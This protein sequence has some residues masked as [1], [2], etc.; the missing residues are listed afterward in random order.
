MKTLKGAQ[1]LLSGVFVIA[2]FT[3]NAQAPAGTEY[4]S[5]VITAAIN[6]VTKKH[7]H[8]KP[9]DDAYSA[10][11]WNRFLH[12]LDPNSNLFLQEDVIALAVYKNQVDDQL[13]SGATTFF[14]AAYAI[15]EQRA[16][17]ASRLCQKILATPFDLKK[18][19]TVMAW[20]KDLPFCASKQ[21]QEE[22]W[23]KLLKYYTLRHYMEMSAAK[24]D[25]A[26]HLAAVD[27]VLEAKAREKVRKW[28]SDYFRQTTGQ[29][30]ADDKFAQYVSAAMFEIDPHTT[31]AAPQDRLMNEQLNKRYY[32]LGIEL[33]TKESD[34]YIKRLL[35]GGT[36]YRSGQVKENDNIIAVADS[37]GEMLPVNG[38]P[39]NEVTGLIRGEKGTA[40]TMKLQQPGEKERTV[41][42]KR[43]EVI[44]QENR[45]KSAVIEKNGKRF[46]YIFLPLFYM[47]PTGTKINGSAND[48]AREVEKLKEQEVDGIVMDLRGNSGGSLDE[49]VTMGYCFVP[50]GPITWLR[51]KDSIRMYSSPAVE[52]LYDGPLTV[53][54]D[55]SS[56]SASEIFAAAMQDRGRGIIVGTSS[57]F[58]KGTA[59]MNINIGKMGNPEK[60][61]A[62]VNYGSM[63]LTT[64]KFYRINGSSTQ[65]KGVIP[66]I[67][68]QDR[69]ELQSIMEKD[70]SSALACDTVGLPP[71]QRLTF[72][73]NYQEVVQHARIRVQQN[74]AFATVAANTRQLKTLQEQPTPLDLLSFGA[75]YQQISGCQKNIQQAKE[76]KGKEVLTVQPSM[77]RNINPARQKNDAVNTAS[78]KEWLEKLGKDIYLAETLSVLEDMLANPVAP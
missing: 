54:V 24:G 10:A 45:A 7:Y 55:E 41:T 69:M 11:V 68:L 50:A 18:K 4:R 5:A 8:P 64:E 43:D 27:P 2:G 57:S 23:R 42:I 1:L 14:D 61:I 13:N 17:E 36:A 66:D 30:G 20:R 74:P 67:V 31:Y 44:D 53:L 71:Y 39:A 34:Y 56:A 60:G 76:L 25:T 65:L 22:L 49:V 29:R 40:V 33:G 6:K 28:Y 37:K 75:A 62:D 9:I 51:G 21:E 19:E 46:G 15:Y 16:G 26:K 12:T 47:D 52:P 63:R 77:L 32:G 78:Y 58:G 72:A 59:Q 35:P 70:F 3:V 38:L 73:F 48:V